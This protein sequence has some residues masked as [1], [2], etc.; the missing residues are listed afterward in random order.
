MPDSPET[1]APS[2]HL[3]VRNEIAA[4]EQV[5]QQVMAHVEARAALSPRAVLRLELVLEEAL[6]NRVWHAYPQE[7]GHPIDLW[8]TITDDAVRLVVEDEGVPFN[9]L[10]APSPEPPRSLAEAAPG[11]LGLMLTRK[12]VREIGY[13][14]V[15]GRNRVTLALDRR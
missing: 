15:D 10:L 3:Q 7:G 8:V 5:R 14:R 2:L 13:E 4:V 12:S 9:P 1:P 6:M 11:G